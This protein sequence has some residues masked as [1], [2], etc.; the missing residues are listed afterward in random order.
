MSRY[1]SNWS[2]YAMSSQPYRNKSS[3]RGYFDKAASAPA[4]AQRVRMGSYFETTGANVAGVIAPNEILLPVAGALGGYFIGK[5]KGNKKW[6]FGAIG[7]VAGR[8]L[9]KVL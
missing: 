3:L 1:M 4:L 5:D 6:L 9:A 7:Y 2:G 8:A